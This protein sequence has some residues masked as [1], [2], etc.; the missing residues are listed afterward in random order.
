MPTARHM[1]LVALGVATALAGCSDKG[2][3]QIRSAGDGPDEFMVL[4][5]EPLEPP[6]D[7][8]VLP[9]PSPG[10]T[11][12]VDTNSKAEAVAALGGRPSALNATSIP[13]SDGAL[14]NYSSR[15]GVPGNIRESLAVADAEF[16]RRQGRGTRL[17][18][19]PVDRYEQAY[20]RERT[21]PFQETWRFR[22]IGAET[23]TAPP[24][25]E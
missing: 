14:V 8:E 20:R 5:V 10:G 6:P 24:E 18:L 2:L 23:P 12:R 22:R 15:Y 19:F 4:P 16:R 7:Y 1:M 25:D 13:A 17:K 11:N 9:A 21:D 3:V